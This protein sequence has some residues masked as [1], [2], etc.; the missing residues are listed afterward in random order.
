MFSYYYNYIFFFFSYELLVMV[1]FFFFLF[2][3]ILS[4]KGQLESYLQ[5]PKIE[6]RTKLT[7]HLQ[8]REYAIDNLITHLSRSASKMKKLPTL[9]ETTSIEA[10]LRLQGIVKKLSN[11]YIALQIQYYLDSAIITPQT[12]SL[13]IR[14][15]LANNMFNDNRTSQK[16]KKQML[17]ILI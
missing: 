5:G 3:A 10:I 4:D 17:R 7:R 2:F 13:Q 11:T 14:I 12:L 6:S 16:N 15:F 8:I 1:C 9:Y